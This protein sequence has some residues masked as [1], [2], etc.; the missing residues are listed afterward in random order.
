MTAQAGDTA[1]K[2][3]LRASL[4]AVRKS[5]TPLQRQ[6]AAAKAACHAL[7]LIEQRR[8]RH[9]ALYLT[10]GSEL[11]TGPL[12]AKLRQR[13][14][15][16]YV[17]RLQTGRL[18]FAPRRSARKMDVILLPLLGFDTHGTRLGQGGGHYDRALNFIRAFQRPLLVGYA[19][20][21]QKIETLPRESHDV[22]L[23]AVITEKGLQWLTG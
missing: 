18:Q 1:S 4:R 20:A 16:L 9:V 5:F 7:R 8:A 6:R 23:D 19:Y 22:R 13:R 14:L 21:L 10:M 11:D 15:H 17:P 12:L 3:S 2:S